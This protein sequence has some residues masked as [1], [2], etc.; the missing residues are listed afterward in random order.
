MDEQQAG[1]GA[2]APGEVPGSGPA[3]CRPTDST[4]GSVQ[5]EGASVQVPR[6]V[7]Y[8]AAEGGKLEEFLGF[9]GGGEGR[10]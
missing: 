1:K 2:E 4:G 8:G 10:G 7:R 9:S 6:G 5:G 3:D